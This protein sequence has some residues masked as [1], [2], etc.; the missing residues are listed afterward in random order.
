M[1]NV[2]VCNHALISHKMAQL[3]DKHTKMP[4][5][6]R[7]VSELSVLLCYEATRD[8]PTV[9]KSVETPL[10]VTQQQVLK[11]GAP[12]IVPI[13]RAGLAMS[14]GVQTV[15]PNSP[16][17]H[18]GVYRDHETLQPVDY[19]SRLPGPLSGRT[20]LLLDPMLATGGSAA[21]G[22]D[23]I[24][25]SNPDQIRLLVLVAAPEG[26]AH[27]QK[28]HPDAAI[29]AAVLDRQLNEHGYILPGL[30]D[31]GDRIFGT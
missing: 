4:E 26:I 8:L 31:A 19:F 30:G 3:R 15:L 12:V 16:V 11:G 25:R 22:I 21:Y 13:L 18:I 20:V 29:F 1:N 7:L 2:T 6:R 5:F 17:G 23:Y 27:V 14:E 9:S 10:E 28:H 24:K